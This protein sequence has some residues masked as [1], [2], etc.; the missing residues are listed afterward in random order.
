MAREFVP[1]FLSQDSTQQL[2]RAHSPDYHRERVKHSDV[3]KEKTKAMK[4]RSGK[5]PEATQASDK[6]SGP[7]SNRTGPLVNRTSRPVQAL[8]EAARGGPAAQAPAPPPYSTAPAQQPQPL[9]VLAPLAGPLPPL[10]APP[11]APNPALNALQGTI[12]AQ[13]SQMRQAGLAQAPQ[14]LPQQVP[15]RNMADFAQAAYV[16]GHSTNKKRKGSNKKNQPAETKKARHGQTV[17]NEPAD[18]G[19]PYLLVWIPDNRNVHQ[20]QHDLIIE[21]GGEKKHITAIRKTQ[22][23]LRKANHTA[24]LP[25]FGDYPLGYEVP[26]MHRYASPPFQ[27]TVA[28]VINSFARLNIANLVKTIHLHGSE[29]S[30]EVVAAIGTV[31]KEIPGYPEDE[32]MPYRFLQ[33]KGTSK[34]RVNMLEFYRISG[35]DDTV[36]GRD[37]VNIAYDRA[38]LPPALKDI[39]KRLIFVTLK[40]Q[41]R[42]MDANEHLAIE[43]MKAPKPWKPRGA[44]DSETESG[45]ETEAASGRPKEEEEYQPPTVVSPAPSAARHLRSTSNISESVKALQGSG[46]SIEGD[47]HAQGEGHRNALPVSEVAAAPEATEAINVAKVL[48]GVAEARLA[49]FGKTATLAE[50]LLAAVSSVA[51]PPFETAWYPMSKKGPYCEDGLGV[52]RFDAT[53]AAAS[54]ALARGNNIKLATAMCAAAMVYLKK[55]PLRE[56]PFE[57]PEL[58]PLVER[59]GIF[60]DHGLL[61]HVEAMGKIADVMCREWLVTEQAILYEADHVMSVLHDVVTAVQRLV[62]FFKSDAASSSTRSKIPKRIEPF[63]LPTVCN[64]A[65]KPSQGNDKTI[66]GVSALH[67][68]GANAAIGISADRFE[69]EF[70]RDF[71]QPVGEG[72]IDPAKMIMGRKIDRKALPTNASFGGMLDILYKVFY[73]FLDEVPASVDDYFEYDLLFEHWAKVF[74]RTIEHERDRLKHRP[75]PFIFPG[76]KEA[77]TLGTQEKDSVSEPSKDKVLAA[78]NSKG[79]SKKTKAV[80]KDTN[81]GVVQV[82]KEAQSLLSG[83]SSLEE[84]SAIRALDKCRDAASLV[85]ALTGPDSHWAYPDDSHP[86]PRKVQSTRDKHVALGYLL[87]YYKEL[88]REKNHPKSFPPQRLQTIVAFLGR[89]LDVNHRATE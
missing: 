80:G 72:R 32:P 7:R 58:W 3:G 37:L 64:Q 83:A 15:M 9:Q 76:S 63:Q 45:A 50:K 79:T 54:F 18:D 75:I 56:T 10:A 19:K 85:L 16:A 57:S 77:P 42:P 49:S 82:G 66:Y 60:G 70:A 5:N 74:V 47:A 22:R 51:A 69:A 24:M 78:S 87:E 55:F 1:R 44:S 40:A 6:A 13:A 48:P 71:G 61:P 88:E 86:V 27:Y 21:A 65:H 67:L 73:R 4:D 2:R 39:S 30:Q 36:N 62:T 81:S 8:R 52:L 59:L 38:S 46:L 34:G 26:N 53:E 20:A 29:T 35:N 33:V 68:P 41:Y 84:E 43:F 31:S 11:A 14:T 25:P 17:Q 89:Y 12:F 23:K 28:H